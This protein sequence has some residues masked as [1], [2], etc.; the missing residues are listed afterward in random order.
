MA[1]IHK[2][3]KV[4]LAYSG[5]LDTS[6]ILTWLRKNYGCKIV[7]FIADLGQ[8]AE[9]AEAVARAKKMGVDELYAED[10][11]ESFVQDY[12]F[13]ML[14][15]N[16]LYE[17]A[18]LL[19]TAIARPL[20]AKRQVEIAEK[21]GA[22]ALAHGATGKGNDQLR[23]ELSYAALNP[24]LKVIAPWREWDM[25]AR[26]Q[27]MEYAHANQ[28]PLPPDCTDS[29]PF[30]MDANLLHHSSEGKVLENP[31]HEAP[32]EAYLWTVAPEDAPDAPSF[33]D[34]E[35]EK[36]DAKALNGKVMTPAA[37]LE[38]LNQMGG[39]HGVGRVDMVENRAT[40][41]KSRGVYETPGGTILLHAHR[42]IES[43]TLDA[44]AAH[45]KDEIMP[46]YAALI[47]QGLWFS[48]ERTM[49]QALIDE[50]QIWVRGRARVKLHKGRI[51]IV[52]KESASSLYSESLSSFDEGK[53]YD[54][55]HAEGFIRLNALR[56]E[57]LARR[58]KSQKS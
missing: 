46:R 13:P 55:R 45:L 41:M 35:F 20:I 36:G 17:G 11:R 4:V 15:A 40:G 23:F 31:A 32:R 42:A 9:T 19:G 44:G 29:P 24:D 58:K 47:Y 27:L 2:A 7:A 33:L 48:P 53:F 6:V 57:S 34:L 5:G 56:L 8:G 51:S 28:I 39:S 43:L 21:T 12:V 14:R 30:S 18:Y 49:L 50:S 1:D 52:E 16:A 37:L 3:D 10:L 26:P 54:H 25:H 38:K 22:D